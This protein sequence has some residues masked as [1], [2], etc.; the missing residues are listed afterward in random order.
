MIYV[1]IESEPPR[2]FYVNP[3]AIPL[4]PAQEA[5]H[6][7]LITVGT[8]RSSADGETPNLTV[9]LRNSSA[10]CSRLFADP[11]LGAKA[12]IMDED[13]VRFS[14]VVRDIE[15]GDDCRMSIEA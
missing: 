10:Q 15:I 13:G 1:R 9:T 12:Q 5:R 4:L 2:S 6:E 8:L 7:L 11:P 3:L 14:G